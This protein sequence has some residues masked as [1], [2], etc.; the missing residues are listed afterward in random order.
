MHEGIY[1]FLFGI[2]F[3]GAGGYLLGWVKASKNQKKPK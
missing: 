2:V 1:G 3:G